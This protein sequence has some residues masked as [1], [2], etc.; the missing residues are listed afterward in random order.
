MAQII[1]LSGNIYRTK[2]F[3]DLELGRGAIL[4]NAVF[5][6]C[7]FDNCKIRDG[8]GTHSILRNMEFKDCKYKGGDFYHASLE[9]VQIENLSTGGLKQA[10]DCF[11]K[12]V[13]LKGKF[14]RLFI[15]CTEHPTPDPVKYYADVDWALDIRDALF[16]EIDLGGIPCKLIIRNAETQIVI[17][18]NAAET[19]NGWRNLP[20]D[21]WVTA[22]EYITDDYPI[23]DEIILI[24]EAYNKN[25]AL[26][27]ESVRMLHELGLAQ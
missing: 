21:T 6:N 2:T 27:I 15:R 12:H 14:D 17:T 20:C 5:E 26:Q 11:F 22:I 10:V 24:P 4:Q 19:N 16:K 23:A 7:L 9:D 13:T 25:Y 18:R 3:V 8:A 1:N